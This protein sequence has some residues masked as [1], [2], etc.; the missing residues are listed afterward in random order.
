MDKQILLIPRVSEKSYQL[1]QSDG[2]YVFIVPKSANKLTV[3]RAVIAQYNVEVNDVRIAH[4]PAKPKRSIRQNGR[5]VNKGFQ[6][7]IKKA[8]VKLK[9]GDSIP[10]FAAEEEERA[11]SE[12]LNQQLQRG[13]K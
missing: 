13:K 2:V 7:G 8:F 1:S 10:I 5:K 11:K 4:L 12:K 3:K 6:P 9:V